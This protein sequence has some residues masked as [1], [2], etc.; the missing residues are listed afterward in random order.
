MENERPPPK[1]RKEECRK[2]LWLVTYT[3]SSADLTAEMLHAK[4]V[5]CDECHTIAWRE[6]K[7]T[8]VHLGTANKL[9]A[10]KLRNA[11]V[12]IE[13][14][15]GIMQSHIVGYDALCSNDKVDSCV[16]EHPGFRRIVQL[17]NEA[18]SELRSW[19]AHG[20]VRTNRRGVLWKFIHSTDPTEKSRAQL[21]A[22]VLEWAPV[23]ERCAA[24]QTEIE[25]LRAT[26]AV[27][28]DEVQHACDKI[29]RLK[30]KY[31][32]K[33]AECAELRQRLGGRL[34]DAAWDK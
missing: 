7:Y 18:P 23:V 25:L 4:G 19:M 8:L 10:S 29:E 33:K 13:R 1:K 20:C 2:H 11:L 15:S 14:D 17:L 32:E 3:A 28:D 24:Q 6:S 31:S 16:E 26:L 12:L 27:R 34:A 21:L 30:Q 9:R 5:M 22:Q